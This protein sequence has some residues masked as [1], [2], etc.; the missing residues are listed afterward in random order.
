MATALA[1]S[2]GYNAGRLVRPI[3]EITMQVLTNDQL[4]RVAPSIFAREE[5]LAKHVSGADI[6]EAA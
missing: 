2:Y 1:R 6:K 4:Y 5:A 3:K